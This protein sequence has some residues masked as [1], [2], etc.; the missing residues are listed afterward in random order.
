MGRDDVQ[1]VNN[2]RGSWRLRCFAVVPGGEVDQ[3]PLS[4]AHRDVHERVAEKGHQTVDPSNKGQTY[5]LHSERAAVRILLSLM[6]S[7]AGGH[8]TGHGGKPT[9]PGLVAAVCGSASS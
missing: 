4:C 6:T 3:A 2:G 7:Q 8:C 1:I 5:A 9:R